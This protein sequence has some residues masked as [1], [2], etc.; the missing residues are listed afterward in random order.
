MND[1][2]SFFG[3][4]DPE[5]KASRPRAV[6]PQTGMEQSWQTASNYAS[7]LDNP[8]GLIRWKLRE[9]VKGIS[10]R[11]DLARM[12]LTGAAIEDNVKA[13]AVIE[14]AH[15]A[16]ALDAKANNGTA[17]HASLSRSFLGNEIPAE[18][19]PHVQAFAAELQRNGLTPVATEVRL[20][21]V[22][23][24]VIGHADWVVKTVDGRYLILDVKTGKLGDSKRKFAV[25]CK[26]YAGAEYI[27]DVEGVDPWTPIPWQIDQ[28]EAILAHVDPETG[29]TS[30]Y[31]IDLV[32]GF[33]GATLAERVRD[34][35]KIEV[36]SPYVPVHHAVPLQNPA[37]ADHA[38]AALKVATQAQTP[39]HMDQHPAPSSAVEPARVENQGT[40]AAAA[41]G[42]E[43]RKPV[44][45]L[46]HLGRTDA[47][48]A[49]SEGR[50]CAPM[51][52]DDFLRYYPNPSSAVVGSTEVTEP[53]PA[54][55]QTAI[56][57]TSGQDNAALQAM[58]QHAVS[59]VAPSTDPAAIEAERADLMQTRNDKAVLQK[60]AGSLG[61]KDLAHNRA[62]L[63]DWIIAT[64]RGADN[65][66]AVMYAKSKGTMGL[67][68]QA[69]VVLQASP[70]QPR[71][72]STPFA[73]KL[74]GEAPD[75]ATIER[76][77]AKVVETSGDHA[78]TDEM[79]EAARARVAWLDAQNGAVKSDALLALERI[80][81]ATEQQHIASIW[82]AVTLGGDMPE[83]WTNELRQAADKRMSEIMTAQ[84]PPPANPYGPQQ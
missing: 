5:R 71:A 12:L 41:I 75:I 60:M 68:G 4:G 48:Q 23:L 26:A 58:K 70:E 54:S 6:N 59:P 10:L 16:V 82:S 64:R 52:L 51:R 63:A 32:L 31:R 14:A 46:A 61:L 33:Y 79:T 74:I 42:L 55:A 3:S 78:W 81:A 83:N 21:C 37:Y 57:G 76:F 84:P 45:W 22:L 28:T 73:L 77:R 1:S 67:P 39:S 35:S 25:Q 56:E 38:V 80:R 50:W 8:H 15:A 30:L 19:L 17:V 11:P 40:V 27:G 49:D 47:I 62:W 2:D 43:L 13:D 34:W 20:L 29:A 24:G 7:P 65:S 72:E 66:A 36:L 18:Y 9:L 69:G 44:D 53:R